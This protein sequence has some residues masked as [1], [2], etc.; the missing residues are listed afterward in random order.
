[1]KKLS[2]L[3]LFVFLDVNCAESVAVLFGEELVPV[4]PKAQKKVPVPEGYGGLC[5]CFPKFSY[6]TFSS[7][8]AVMAVWLDL[9]TLVQRVLDLKP[10]SDF[11]H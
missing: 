7:P 3:K 4:A 9:S 6:R 1:M 8:L 10:P 5:F 11:S 2:S